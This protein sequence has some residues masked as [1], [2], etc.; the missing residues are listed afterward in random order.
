MLDAAG[1]WGTGPFILKDGTSTLEK[2]SPEVVLEANPNYWNASRKP[3]VQRVV[4][5]NIPSAMRAMFY[6]GLPIVFIAIAWLFAQRRLYVDWF[7][8]RKLS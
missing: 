1:P 8:E 5:D 6:A 4:F 2:R 3:K 7:E